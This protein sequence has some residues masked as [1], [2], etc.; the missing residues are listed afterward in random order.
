MRA[1][2]RGLDIKVENRIIAWKTARN[3]WTTAS[4]MCADVQGITPDGQFLYPDEF[5]A[6]VRCRE[7]PMRW[8][9]LV[10]LAVDL[11]PRGAEL[12]VFEPR[13]VDLAHGNVHVALA[14]D[15]K[16]DEIKATKGKRIRAS[17]SSPTFAPFSKRCT[18]RQ[19]TVRCCLRT[20][21]AEH[22]EP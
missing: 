5:L 11:Y 13:D 1:L 12:R 2:S 22:P 16:A 7:V 17:R 15:K 4:Q 21:I 3:I 18:P 8:R 19:K 6:F 20:T 14:L 10:A 9:R